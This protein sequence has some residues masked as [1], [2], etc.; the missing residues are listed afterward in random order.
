M[1]IDAFV[2]YFICCN[3]F[4]VSFCVRTDISAEVQPIGVK[5]CTMVGMGLD[6]V[7]SSLG[8]TAMCPNFDRISKIVYLKPH[9]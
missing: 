6:W 1:T 7:F 4:C 9:H 8:G 2:G 5:Y 3:S